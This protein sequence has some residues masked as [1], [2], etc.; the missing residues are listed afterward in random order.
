MGR[1]VDRARRLAGRAA[2][3]SK[4]KLIKILVFPARHGANKSEV[5]PRQGLSAPRAKSEDEKEPLTE[6]LTAAL[7]DQARKLLV[8][9]EDADIPADAKVTFDPSAIGIYADSWRVGREA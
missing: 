8:A 6:E 1:H 7:V 4:W 9:S 5:N 3:A 2:T